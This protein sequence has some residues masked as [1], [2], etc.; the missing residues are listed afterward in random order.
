MPRRLVA[1]LAA[2]VAVASA[3]FVAVGAARD[4]GSPPRLRF[5]QD[6]PADVRLASDATFER[7]LDRFAGRAACLDD[8]S[9]ELVRV[10]DGGDARY[11][12]DD[13]R[14]DIRI[15]TTP[16]RYEESLAHE[17]AHHIERTCD[18]F[19]PLRVALEPLVGGEG[20]PWAS[21]PI[22]EEIPSERFAEAVVELVN[23]VRIRHVDTVAVDPAARE[24]IARWGAGAQPDVGG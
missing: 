15:P 6:V 8:V 24:L 21:G 18:E 2:L 14:I 1:R 17:L 16:S 9:V 4:G 22:W 13:R 19:E 10:V 12:T 5:T 7:F 3:A 11:V 20:V 23:G